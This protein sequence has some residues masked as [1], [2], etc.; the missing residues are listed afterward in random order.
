MIN[1]KL[2]KDNI[3]IVIYHG[4]CADGFGSA[5]IIWLYYKKNYG[6]EKADA[7]TYIPGTYQQKDFSLDKLKDKNIIMCDFSYKNDRL[8]EIINVSNSFMILD[9]HKSSMIDLET[10]QPELKIF[11]MERSGVGITWDFFNPGTQMNLFL[12]HIQDRDLWKKSMK[13]NDEFITY[14]HEQEFNFELWEKFMDESKFSSAVEIGSNWLEYKNIIINKKI[15]HASFILHELNKKLMCVAY[16]NSTEYISEIGNLL[17]KIPYVD[18]VV[19]YNLDIFRNSTYFSLR[20]A[21]TGVDVSVIANM[22]G[23]GG[24]KGAAGFSRQGLNPLLWNIVPDHDTVNLIKYAKSVSDPDNKTLSY[25][26]CK[27]SEINTMWTTDL[28]FNFIKAKTKNNFLFVYQ[29]ELPILPNET[30]LLNPNLTITTKKLYTIYFNS[31]FEDIDE[32]SQILMNV[33]TEIKN[34]SMTIESEKEFKSIIH[35][36]NDLVDQDEPSINKN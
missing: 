30:D 15:N 8:R 2:N 23:G 6:K 34:K 1:K 11:D 35:L 20:S 17:Y 18:F 28:Y 31:S 21:P 5:F 9:H 14:L 7:I 29:T 16:C 24:H 19:V 12:A 13:F 4:G 3:D 10:I 33:N 26:L 22:F 25:T 36:F 32:D 27:I